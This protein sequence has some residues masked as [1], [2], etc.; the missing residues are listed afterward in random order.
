MDSFPKF[1]PIELS[2]DTGILTSGIMAPM[3]ECIAAEG[4]YLAFRASAKLNPEDY[5]QLAKLVEEKAEKPH[6]VRVLLNFQDFHGWT[7]PGA[8]AAIKFGI[9]DGKLVEKLAIVGEG[10][11]E[12]ALAWIVEVF[13]SSIVEFFDTERG[14]EAWSWLHADDTGE[15]LS[16]ASF[17]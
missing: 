5:D 2:G 4:R 17:I 11:S 10:K 13:G 14:K 9:K 16:Y 12:G 7:L 8:G 15:Y 3:L 1:S 6:T